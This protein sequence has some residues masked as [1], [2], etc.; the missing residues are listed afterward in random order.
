[1]R[2][3]TKTPPASSIPVFCKDCGSRA[4]WVRCPERDIYTESGNLLMLSYVC[5]VCEAKTLR[6]NGNENDTRSNND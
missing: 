5:R 2:T 1:M 4:T 6:R 3:P